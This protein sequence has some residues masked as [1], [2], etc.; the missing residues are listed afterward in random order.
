LVFDLEP[1]G[2]YMAFAQKASSSDTAYTTMLCF[3]RA[4]SIYSTYG[5]HLGCDMNAHNY[6]IKNVYLDGVSVAYNGSNYSGYTGTIPIVTDV[7]ITAQSDGGI[8]WNIQTSK[9]RVS[10]GIIVGYWS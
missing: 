8:S 9:L 10:N 1:N 4:N 3:S 5:M 2:K 6:T 7:T